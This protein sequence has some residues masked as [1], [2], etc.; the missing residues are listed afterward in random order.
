ME[1]ADKIDKFRSADCPASE[2]SQAWRGEK[3]E[4][5]HLSGAL[6]RHLIDARSKIETAPSAQSK[7]R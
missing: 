3:T 7:M 5:E 6:W 2:C 4:G 1:N